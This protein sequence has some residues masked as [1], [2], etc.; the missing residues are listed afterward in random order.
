MIQIGQN[1]DFN[2]KILLYNVKNCDLKVKI[3]QH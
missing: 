2:V 1:F 3:C